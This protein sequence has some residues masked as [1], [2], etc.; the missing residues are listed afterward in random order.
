VATL[1]AYD[2][3]RRLSIARRL[4][5][6]VPSGRALVLFPDEFYAP[7]LQ[8]N[9]HCWGLVRNPIAEASRLPAYILN[10]YTEGAELSYRHMDV[11]FAPEYYA[12]LTVPASQV[13][14]FL[15]KSDCDAEVLTRTGGDYWIQRIA[16]FALFLLN[17]PLWG[18]KEVYYK[19]V[20]SVEDK[21]NLPAVRKPRVRGRAHRSQP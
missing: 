2:F 12:E 21:E 14:V 10:W 4:A 16:N 20:S 8:M 11:V 18:G 3:I 13:V 1:S 6:I 15:E 9:Y 5:Q 19:R 7:M 17:K